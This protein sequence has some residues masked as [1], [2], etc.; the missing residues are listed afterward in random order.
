MRRHQQHRLCKVERRTSD[1]KLTVKKLNILS[2]P[3][4]HAAEA[5]GD[6]QQWAWAIICTI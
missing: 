1:R 6:C 2:V 5:I 3:E 4:H